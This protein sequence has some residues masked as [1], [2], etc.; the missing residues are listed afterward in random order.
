MHSDHVYQQVARLGSS[1]TS[2]TDHLETAIAPA[3]KPLKHLSS[4][5]ADQAPGPVGYSNAANAKFTRPV[6]SRLQASAP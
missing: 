6:R 2:V 5:E 4:S 1:P 3:H